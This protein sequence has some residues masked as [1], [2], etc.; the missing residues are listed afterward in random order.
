VVLLVV[1]IFIALAY[2]CLLA[3]GGRVL[4]L[5]IAGRTEAVPPSCMR[6]GHRIDRSLARPTR[7]G[8]CGSDLAADDAI[9]LFRRRPRTAM[10][11]LF[12]AAMVV[13]AC[14]P[15]LIAFVFRA[16]RAPAAAALTTLSTTE[17]AER[18][19]T[20]DGDDWQMRQEAL[21]RGTAATTSDEDLGLLASAYIAWR[22]DH[23]DGYRDAGESDLIVLADQRG[24]VDDAAIGA[25][26][27][28]AFERPKLSLPD[29][30]RS[31]HELLIGDP[32]R[33]GLGNL[34]HSAVLVELTLDG[35]PLPLSDGGRNPI[36]RVAP[37]GVGR[38]VL[39]AEPGRRV[40]KAVYEESLFIAASGNAGAFATPRV[41]RRTIDERTIH[42]VA[43]DAPTWIA[44]SAPSDRR[45]EVERAVRANRVAIDPV[46]GASLCALRVDVGVGPVD[47]IALAFS[48]V[49]VLDGIEH[50]IGRLV[51]AD[52][53]RLHWERPLFF[54]LP[55]DCPTRPPRT[56]R[57]VFRPDPAIVESM[58]GIDTVWGETIEFDEVPVEFGTIGEAG[59]P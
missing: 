5:A 21:R 22:A 3:F 34:A 24:L 9:R 12:L 30:V 20:K 56:A 16:V 4:V 45:A 40:L 39:E 27:A 50:P 47:G 1:P 28:E 35:R 37:N 43:R 8:E 46:D 48:V 51:Q 2:A 15:F 17:L 53:Q 33:I 41:V 31:G 42:V 11:G 36:E 14:T 57:V 10:L 49:V 52:T 6:C 25:Y 26:I 19:R 54:A 44:T 18:I 7:C 23:P 32:G 13:A 58:R 38:A 55:I 29:T 59:G